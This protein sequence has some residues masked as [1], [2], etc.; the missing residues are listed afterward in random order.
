MEVGKADIGALA[1]TMTM[2]FPKELVPKTSWTSYCFSVLAEGGGGANGNFWKTSEN[3]MTTSLPLPCYPTQT[4]R[5]AVVA[6]LLQGRSI[7][8]WIGLWC[9][10]MK[11]IVHSYKSG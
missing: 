6:S 8:V 1:H 3:M 7:L 9:E 2:T 10:V 11:A 4:E 5:K